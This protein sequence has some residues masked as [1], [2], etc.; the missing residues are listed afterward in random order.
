MSLFYMLNSDLEIKSLQAL[1]ASSPWLFDQPVGDLNMGA[2]STLQ[3]NAFQ[4]V[5]L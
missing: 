1:Y 5:K 3:T 4:K 2:D